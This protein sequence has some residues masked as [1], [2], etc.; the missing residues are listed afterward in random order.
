[1]SIDQQSFGGSGSVSI[2]E[3]NEKAKRR[4]LLILILFAAALALALFFGSGLV[5]G[6]SVPVTDS[7]Q[8]IYTQCQGAIAQQSLI[9][10]Q[11]LLA[12]QQ[13]YSTSQRF[14]ESDKLYMTFCFL[15]GAFLSAIL[16]YIYAKMTNR[17]QK[18]V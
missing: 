15:A 18:K 13:A 8:S 10:N 16:V 2:Q 11:T 6:Q 17:S 14:S 5:Q 4:L 9:L 3:P 1:M 12:C 7:Y